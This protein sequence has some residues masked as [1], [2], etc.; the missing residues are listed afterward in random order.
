MNGQSHTQLAPTLPGS[1]KAASQAAHRARRKLAAAL[2][3][4]LTAS[5]A[6]DPAVPVGGRKPPDHSPGG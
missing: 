1:P 6:C 4:R 2:A 3:H 5:R